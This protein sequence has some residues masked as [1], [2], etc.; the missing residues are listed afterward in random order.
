MKQMKCFPFPG[1]CRGLPYLCVLLL[2]I[3]PVIH[4]SRAADTTETIEPA[5]PGI[6]TEPGELN[7]VSIP[8]GTFDMG[9]HHDLGGKDHGN[10]EVPIHSV[11]VDSFHMGVTVTGC[12][13]TNLPSGGLSG[14]PRRTAL[15]PGL[16]GLVRPA[17]YIMTQASMRWGRT[18]ERF[19]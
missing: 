6:E 9:D 5:N 12:G 3:L 11:S 10:D 4:C 19:D 16:V 1:L 13:E 18:G 7:T 15:E 14:G 2:L 8:G 17:M